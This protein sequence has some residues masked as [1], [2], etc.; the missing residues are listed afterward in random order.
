MSQVDDAMNA[1]ALH[2]EERSSGHPSFGQSLSTCPRRESADHL[3]EGPLG[4]RQEARNVVLARLVK[5]PTE[6]LKRRLVVLFQLDDSHHVDGTQPNRGTHHERS[7]RPVRF[8]AGLRSSPCAPSRR[9]GI[10]R[11]VI[12]M[13]LAAPARVLSIDDHVATVDYGG[14]ETKARLDALTE[15]VAPGDY[16]LIHTGFAIR[17]LSAEDAEETLKL[18]DEFAAS[19]AETSQNEMGS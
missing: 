4:I 12:L 8:A 7:D 18:F 19:L 9:L 14:V 2:E 1:S 3:L 17:R 11:A 15:D 16:L 13:C 6:V 10:I 5:L